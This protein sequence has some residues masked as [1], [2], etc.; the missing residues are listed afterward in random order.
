MSPY[1]VTGAAT[2]VGQTSATLTGTVCPN[3]QA[4]SYRFE[5]GTTTAYGSQTAATNAIS[6][7]AP[8][9]AS[10]ALSGL[11]ADTLYHYRLTATSATDTSF[12]DDRTFTTAPVPSGGGVVTAA[13][14]RLWHG[15]AGS[16]SHRR[17]SPLRTAGRA[18]AQPS[19][20]ARAQPSRSRST[21]RQASA[22]RSS[23]P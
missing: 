3:N 11:A 9:A 5:Y 16:T 22:S 15:S 6:G 23:A 13:A 18:R 12:G 14:P 20:G 1:A 17:P 2:D 10:A 21:G 19:G 7:T 8:A 4:T